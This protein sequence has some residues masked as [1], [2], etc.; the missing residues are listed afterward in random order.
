MTIDIDQLTEAELI[1]LN[2]RIV[3]RLRFLNQMR[4]HV[5]M[6][7]FK[8]GDRVTFQ[9]PG[10]GPLE[11]M[12]TRYNK[13]TVTVIAD[14]GQRWNVSPTLIRSVK[15]AKGTNTAGSNVVVLNQR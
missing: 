13:K 11:G 1:D 3:E 9:P 12:L 4:A 5:E 8:I 7:E 10:Q 14:T 15:P 6:L 2:H